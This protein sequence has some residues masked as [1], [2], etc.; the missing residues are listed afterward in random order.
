MPGIKKLGFQEALDLLQNLPSASN[1]A[2]TDYSSSKE[3]TANNLLEFSSDSKKDDQ[4]T[5]QDSECN[6][7]CS[8]NT[9]LPRMQFFKKRSI[10][11]ALQMHS[12]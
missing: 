3:V 9:V 6:S 5:E 1:D 7:S 11:T 10:E 12:M 8:E 4:E 2:L